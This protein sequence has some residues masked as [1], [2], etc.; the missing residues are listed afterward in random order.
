MLV[1]RL[2]ASSYFD[3]DIIGLKSWIVQNCI[4]I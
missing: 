1:I 2:C 3:I 4:N